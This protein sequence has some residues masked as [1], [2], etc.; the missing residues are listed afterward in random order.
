MKE[1]LQAI[2]KALR[3]AVSSDTPRQA[4][5]GAAQ[6]LDV[7]AAKV[8]DDDGSRSLALTLAS[9][10]SNHQYGLRGFGDGSLSR[11][12]DLS[13][14]E[15]AVIMKALQAYG[16]AAGPHPELRHA[17]RAAWMSGVED[18]RCLYDTALLEHLGIGTFQ[19]LDN[20]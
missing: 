20:E 10:I 1:Q 11:G 19:E 7:L 5:R 16:R 15:K 8:Q 2:A 4:M 18:F 3:D 12:A 13:D 6:Y 9:A 17:V 14:K